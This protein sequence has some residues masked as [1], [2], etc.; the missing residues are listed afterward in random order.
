METEICVAH[1]HDAIV[2]PF[3][4]E[5]ATPHIGDLLEAACV[6]DTHDSTIVQSAKCR[7]VAVNDD[8][9][10]SLA[11]CRPQG[12]G[13]QDVVLLKVVS[14]G[15]GRKGLPRS[16]AEG[17]HGGTVG[18][19]SGSFLVEW[20]PVGEDRCGDELRHDHTAGLL[21]V[22]AIVR[23]EVV[24]TLCGCEPIHEDSVVVAIDARGEFAI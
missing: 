4:A 12:G 15:R 23:E 5:R 10:R 1:N 3:E 9:L 17:R 13:C 11:W 8:V 2:Q 16:G 7:T 14:E 24:A 19:N 6:I 22:E 18:T 21:W 20:L